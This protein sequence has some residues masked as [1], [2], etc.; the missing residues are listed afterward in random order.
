M[1][2]RRGSTQPAQLKKAPESPESA[3]GLPKEPQMES[4][5]NPKK[6]KTT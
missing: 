4:R 6:T 3:R 2:S 5:G 1:S